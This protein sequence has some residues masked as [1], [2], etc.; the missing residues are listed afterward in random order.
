MM[1]NLFWINFQ[2]EKMRRRNEF[3][4]M[5]RYRAFNDSKEKN[6]SSLKDYTDKPNKPLTLKIDQDVE[7]DRLEKIR[8]RKE[9]S[10][11]VRSL[12]VLPK[13]QKKQENSVHPNNNP[14]VHALRRNIANSLQASSHDFS[15]QKLGETQFDR[16]IELRKMQYV[17]VGHVS[18]DLFRSEHETRFVNTSDPYSGKT[19]YIPNKN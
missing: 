9:F 13:I 1:P 18:R 12:D 2:A 17:N 19:L 5:T 4:Q 8:R 7:N 16:F 10:Q 3:S 6:L 14:S 15:N 11:L